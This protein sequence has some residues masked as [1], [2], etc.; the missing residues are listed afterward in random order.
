MTTTITTWEE[1]KVKVRRIH[2][3]IRPKDDNEIEHTPIKEN[4]ATL[5]FGAWLPW[6]CYIYV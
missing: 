5:L 2:W 6:L 4:G 3:E 1:I